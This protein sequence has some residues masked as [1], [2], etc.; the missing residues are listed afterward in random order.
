MRLNFNR[1]QV[2]ITRYGYVKSTA[3]ER[4]LSTKIPAMKL[5]STWLKIGSSICLKCLGKRVISSPQKLSDRSM[6]GSLVVSQ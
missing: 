2:F 1:R 3:V 6:S 4:H 5:S